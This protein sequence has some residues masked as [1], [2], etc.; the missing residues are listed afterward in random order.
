METDS[1]LFPKPANV[2]PQFNETASQEEPKLYRRRWVMLAILTL[3]TAEN[4]TQWLFYSAISNIVEYHFAVSSFPAQLLS[5]NNLA[6]IMIFG[7]PAAFVINKTTLKSGCLISGLLSLIALW[8][9]FFGAGRNG[10]ALSLCGQILASLGTCFV[11]SLPAQLAS[12]WFGIYERSLATSIAA[13]G[14]SF[15]MGSAYLFA[16]QFVPD[17]ESH[18]KI[19]DGIRKSI[20]VQAMLCST[21]IIAAVI[22]FDNVPPTPPSPS[23]AAV[24]TDDQTKP[25]F[26]TSLKEL[27]GNTSFVLTGLTF[28]AVSGVLYAF[29][30]LLSDIVLDNYDVSEKLVGWVGFIGS[31]I[32]IPGML[33]AG[34]WLDRTKTYKKSFVACS[35]FIFITSLAFT[36]A[37]KYNAPIEVIFLIVALF[38]FLTAALTTMGFLLGAELTYP[39][40][41]ISSS[42]VLLTCGQMFGVLVLGITS[43]TVASISSEFVNWFNTGICLAAFLITP[44]IKPDFRRLK[45]DSILSSHTIIATNSDK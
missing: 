20:L 6:I 35:G 37:V 22:L 21:T 45:E 32:G 43:Y 41:E 26:L 16:V 27:L 4:L 11:L 5:L 39:V 34:F 19:Q 30:S 29:F 36:L 40:P 23:Q 44:F 8:I 31:V 33:L 9:K 2:L 42:G 14:L 12:I 1:L 18:T 3:L 15:G 28:G 25:S 7:L 13:S 17:V 10:F 38:G 24:S